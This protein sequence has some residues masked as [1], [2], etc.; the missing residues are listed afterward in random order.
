MKNSVRRTIDAA[1]SEHV[2]TPGHKYDANKLRYDLIP[3]EPLR[4]VAEVYT[5][6]AAKYAPRQWE[7]GM[8][9]GRVYSA[10]QR[11]M[12]LFWSGQDLD[13][14][15]GLPHLAHAAW[16]LLALLEY[17]E[18]HPDLDDRQVRVNKDYGPE[19]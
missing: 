12:S 10:A 11:H 8:D 3:V 19:A 5:M 16:N 9:W 7:G 4:Q 17:A 6:G 1:S 18:T 15:S 2:I 13:E 14:E